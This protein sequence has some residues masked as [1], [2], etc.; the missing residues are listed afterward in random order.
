MF[1]NMRCF[2]SPLGESKRSSLLQAKSD[3]V[4]FFKVPH[5]NPLPKER[6][7]VR[8]IILLLLSLFINPAFA[9][10]TATTQQATVKLLVGGYN[11]A[12]EIEAGISYNL[13]PG[14]K[15][16][17]RTAGDNGYPQNIDS[18][19]SNNVKSLEVSWPAPTRFSDKISDNLYSESY[20]YKDAAL[21]PIKI[22]PADASK[23]TALKLNI[24]YAICAE[25]CISDNAELSFDIP[26]AY[27]SPENIAIINAAKTFIPKANGEYGIQIGNV[28]SQSTDESQYLQIEV[29]SKDSLKDSDIFVEAGTD[30][31]FFKPEKI[32]E[33]NKVIFKIPVTSLTDKKSLENSAL[34]I[35]IKRGDQAVEKTIKGSDIGV[36][37][38][39]TPQKPTYTIWL[40]L[41]FGFIGGLIL[42]IM[43]CVLPVLSIKLLGVINQSGSSKK[44]IATSFIVTAIGIILSFIG[45]SVLIIA[46]KAAGV[47][48]GWGFHFQEPLFIAF[49]VVVVSFFAANL[50]G[51]FEIRAPAIG[52]VAM[53]NGLVG[54]FLTG[55]FATLLATPC[56]APFL[57]VAVGFALSRGS[58]EIITTFAAMG[59]G[60]ATPYL[61]FS[62]FPQM[63]TKLP[64]P[65]KWMVT[66]K[67][68]MA[69][70]LVA[71]AVWLVWVLASQLGN[72][73]EASQAQEK[74]EAFKPEDI[75]TLVANG[76]TV[77]VDVT[78]DWCLTCKVNKAFVLDSTEIKEKFAQM[79]V[80]AMRADWTSRDAAI[81]S[82]LESNN[83]AGIP[84]NIV[85]GPN[86]PDGIILS[87]LLSKSGVVDAL[88]RASVKK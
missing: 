22:I 21:F 72:K 24:D 49:M 46:L 57:G 29:S 13:K 68:F 4:R 43:P 17:W 20:G 3:S 61:L 5:H 31:A 64:R 12:G 85:Y 60:M 59:I 2:Y 14:W 30:F 83:R 42:N 88:D 67:K 25:I 10:D 6:G 82:Y 75:K 1:N 34:T 23:A 87:E 40:I 58:F 44:Q 19:A 55:M 77:F 51:F 63:I 74:W 66:V 86:A 76:K 80:V 78:A 47:V 52:S 84:F 38:D 71:T 27:K 48:V 62:I 33:D 7:L 50:W 32:S 41:L 65:G 16:Y 15:I 26:T 9:A 73:N 70:L 53:K 79:D 35:T 8:I 28:T 39:T 37:T 45:L 36:A 69:L 81:E 11:G 54:D 18:S 56:T